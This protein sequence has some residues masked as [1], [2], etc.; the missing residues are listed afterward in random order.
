MNIE[1]GRVSWIE[2]QAFVM[3]YGQCFIAIEQNENGVSLTYSCVAEGGSEEVQNY[4]YSGKNIS[5]LLNQISGI[6][7]NVSYDDE[8]EMYFS[9]NEA[10]GGSE[11]SIS[12]G[13]ND[14]V[15][16]G[17]EGYSI[18]DDI[19]VSVIELVQKEFP[20]NNV[21]FGCLGIVGY[22]DFDSDECD[23]Y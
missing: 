9:E 16:T 23:E 14:D 2:I 3:M 8:N 5:D 10:D 1:F 22:E 11:W 13:E 6:D 21:F 15:K 17:I 20:F 4:E 7:L 18:N 12:F 19:I